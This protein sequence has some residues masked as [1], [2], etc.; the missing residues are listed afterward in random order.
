MEEQDFSVAVVAVMAELAHKELVALEL[1]Y[2]VSQ[3][4]VM[5]MEVMVATA[6]VFHIRSA[7]CQ[8]VQWSHP[9]EAEVV[10][11]EAVADWEAHYKQDEPQRERRQRELVLVVVVAVLTLLQAVRRVVMEQM[12]Y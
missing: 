12:A 9:V 4:L 1:F 5:P 8:P 10:V 3:E 11:A 6:P 7:V 2:R